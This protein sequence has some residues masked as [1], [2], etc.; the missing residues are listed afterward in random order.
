MRVCAGLATVSLVIGGAAAFAE[1][2]FDRGPG[3]AP[4]PWASV[5]GDSRNSDYVPLVTP[6][7]VELAWRVFEGAAVWT[8]PSVGLDGAIWFT[9]GR[10]AGTSHLHAVSPDGQLRWESAPDDVGPGAVTSAPVIDADGDVYVGDDDHFWAFH[11]DGRPKWRAALAPLGV[12]GPFVTG[13]IVGEH[14]GGISINGQVVLFRRASGDLAVPVLDLPGGP[15]PDGDPLPDWVWSGLMD[16]ATR[17]RTN[18]VLMGLKYEVTNTPAVHPETGRIYLL[19]GGRTLEEGLFYGIDL[20]EDGLRIAF[21][22]VLG[23]GTGTSPA[24]SH[25]GE[26]VFAFEGDGSVI[27]LDADT[28]ALLYQKDVGGVPASPSTGPDG[29]V[30]VRARARRGTLDGATGDVLWERRYP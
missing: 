20:A 29:A 2:V 13:M 19:A 3:Y 12:R 14:V 27:A 9:T 21:E 7:D 8:A 6:T 4:S 1:P 25:D 17:E 15:S 10:G 23:P 28:G 24:I 30:S 5:H 18:D 22:T 16:E 26:R 11:A